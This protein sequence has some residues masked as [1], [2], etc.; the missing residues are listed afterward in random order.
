MACSARFA[1][2]LGACVG[3]ALPLPSVVAQPAAAP[4][5]DLRDA[6]MAA[7]KLFDDKS[8]QPA[9][10]KFRELVASTGSPN[11]RL[12]VARCLN[13]LDRVPEAYDEMKAAVREAGERAATEPKYEATRDAAAAELALLEP[14]VAHVVIA[15]AGDAKEVTVKLNGTAVDASKLGTPITVSPGRQSIVV[16]RSGAPAEQKELTIDGGQTQTFA[17]SATAS[18]KVVDPKPELAPKETGGEL[19][20][21]G[22]VV[23]GLGVASL[24]T[25]TA[26]A[27]LSDQKFASIEEECGGARC[28]DP[29]YAD[30]ID[31]GKQLELIANITLVAGAVLAAG[32]VPLIIF[33]GPSEATTTTASLSPRPGGATLD[34]ITRF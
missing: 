2:L 16:E 21:V 28:S 23:G 20:I 7:Q 17:I 25:F 27:V 34:V 14:K 29:S 15:V 26:T 8:Y 1:W 19:R 5:K 30:E 3:F 18:G 22:I 31:A 32:S 10:E 24:A 4:E 33:G 12:Y 13:A 11:A 9:L 6:F